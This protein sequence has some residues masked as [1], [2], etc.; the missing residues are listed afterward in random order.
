[1]KY[2]SHS[3]TSLP[4]GIFNKLQNT[5][6]AT[7]RLIRSSNNNNN[8]TNNNNNNNN[9]NRESPRRNRGL[10]TRVDENDADTEDEQHNER[11]F[12]SNTLG[13]PQRVSSGRR[14]L[15]RNNPRLNLTS[16]YDSSGSELTIDES[17]LTTNNSAAADFVQRILGTTN[18]EQQQ[19]RSGGSGDKSFYRDRPKSSTI[20][21]SSASS[22]HKCTLC[23][24]MLNRSAMSIDSLE[25]AGAS[26]DWCDQ[27][28]GR[29]HHLRWPFIDLP[30]PIKPRLN[31][32]GHYIIESVCYDLESILNDRLLRRLHEWDYP[33]FEL[34]SSMS[35]T[36]LSKMSYFIFNETGLLEVFRIPVPEF[37]YYFRALESG[38]HN[39]PCKLSSSLCPPLDC[40]TQ[41]ILLSI[42]II[43]Q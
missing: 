32:R 41:F 36:I 15:M 20:D 24:A 18:S 4:I 31:P 6:T 33:I 11:H 2:R 17:H 8:N 39:K 16:D 28:G 27:S 34:S 5:K 3:T 38:Y 21:G 43:L 29:L 26:E 19:A 37:L 9:N 10:K 1:M 13:T 14:D 25:Q 23:G 35:E 7:M 12:T 22:N 42:L 30:P 40:P